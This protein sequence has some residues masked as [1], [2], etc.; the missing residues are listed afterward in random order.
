M[1][2]DNFR[3]TGNEVNDGIDRASI[4]PGYAWELIDTA[5]FKRTENIIQNGFS[6]VSYPNLSHS[7]KVHM[8][9]TAKNAL[10]MWRKAIENSKEK[11]ESST[12]EP[13][14]ISAAT[15]HDIG[16]SP[17]SHDLEAL[18][19]KYSKKSHEQVAGE[20]IAGEYSL[21]EFYKNLP[22]GI[23]SEHHRQAK[24][25]VLKAMPSIPDILGHYGI[26]QETVA[27]IIDKT[28]AN[29]NDNHVG[30]NLFLREIIDGKVIDADKFEYLQ[31]DPRNA[32]ITETGF[33][34]EGLIADLRIVQY[35]G[36]YH[37]AVTDAAIEIIS[38]LLATRSYMY[39]RV[40]THKTVLKIQ[41]MYYESYKRFLE[42]LADEERAK[43][44]R[45]LYLLDDHLFESFITSRCGE[46]IASH[47]YITAK[48]NRREK[49]AIAYQIESKDIP[50]AIDNRQSQKGEILKKLFQIY[51]EQ[52]EDF[53]RDQILDRINAGNGKT[54]E[55]HKIIV[56]FPYPRKLKTHEQLLADF[57]LF[58]VD[59]RNT[60]I[61]YPAST[62]LQKE[63][64]S[65][66]RIENAFKNFCRHQ[67]SSYFMV[68][69]PKEDVERVKKASEEYI[70]T[71]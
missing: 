11:M 15:L 22:D 55:N 65:D 68:L 23:I 21:L 3:E 24:I 33:N 51:G 39:C 12:Y 25:K 48:E 30:K 40:Y 14:L 64:F 71:L 38:L 46:D 19:K 17:L 26:N 20:I 50:L 70:A 58:V 6:R 56:Y 52:P 27:Q 1:T 35:D 57:Q 59:H 5:E 44:G 66:E 53:I 49:Y 45:S 67:T 69:C 42:S 9:G 61:I 8:M 62:K 34:P 16:H 13:P 36:N 32:G 47:L 41:A 18:I 43:Y 10:K 54:L 37:L 4:L 28:R 2:N 63:K 29:K 7:R 60:S 31:R